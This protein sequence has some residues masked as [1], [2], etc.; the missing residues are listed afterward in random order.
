MSLFMKAG[1]IGLIS[2]PVLMAGAAVQTAPAEEERGQ[3]TPF[4]DGTV[5]PGT[6]RDAT[7]KRLNGEDI[8]ERAAYIQGVR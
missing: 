8:R 6:T 1:R 2:A 4:A 3:G 5:A 7:A